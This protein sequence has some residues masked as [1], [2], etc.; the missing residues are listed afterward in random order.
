MTLVVSETGV[1]NPKHLTLQ[2]LNHVSS[3]LPGDCTSFC[4]FN[5]WKCLYQCLPSLEL[6]LEAMAPAK[7]DAK[8]NR[9]QP[10]NADG[11]HVH[12]GEQ[13]VGSQDTGFVD[14]YSLAVKSMKSV[15]TI[16]TSLPQGHQLTICKSEIR[17]ENRRQKL[18]LDYINA[19]NALEEEISAAFQNDSNR[20]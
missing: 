2:L 1:G 19:M 5:H 6:L 9:N 16:S 12:D 18:R 17:R 8:A 10:S 11:E 4:T 15:S 3:Q 14:I 20:M 7:K 13:D